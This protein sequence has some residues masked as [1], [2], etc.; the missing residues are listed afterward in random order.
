[1]KKIVFVFCFLVVG[2][3]L[4]SE[5]VYS[6]G[7]K[8][9]IIISTITLGVFFGPFLM[10]DDPA[11]PYNLDKNDVNFFDR[12][13]MYPYNRT[14]YNFRYIQLFV[15]PFLPLIPPFTVGGWNIIKGF[16]TWF[17]YGV[18]YIQAYLL[19]YG[20]RLFFGNIVDRYR[21]HDYFHTPARPVKSN[22]FP[23]GTTATAF[24]PAT[25]FSVTF[26]A[27]Y[28]DSP[29]KIPVII[30]SYSLAATVGITRIF[31]GVHFM[32][33]VIAGAAIGTFYGWLIPRLHK[34]KDNNITLDFT[35]NGMLL[36][37]K[38]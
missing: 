30:G 12:S 11:I 2:F 4:Y 28:P 15:L 29:W 8:K 25:L 19:T 3:N 17:T 18:M 33:D 6:L 5:S 27:E 22:S 35:G 34:R 20:T 7:L 9:D 14:I 13:L 10:N 23:S 36:S 32:T 21:P 26:A 24:V 1:M 37:L 38:Y 16:N 31:S